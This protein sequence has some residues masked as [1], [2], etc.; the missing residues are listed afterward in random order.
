MARICLNGGTSLPF[1]IG[2]VQYQTSVSITCDITVFLCT[3]F[4]I[5]ARTGWC[6]GM[7]KITLPQGDRHQCPQ[8]YHHVW[9]TISCKCD[10]HKRHIGFC[11]HYIL[12]SFIEHFLDMFLSRY[13]L[14]SSPYD[15]ESD[16]WCWGNSCH[17][18]SSKNRMFPSMA[19]L[20][21]GAAS[22]VDYQLTR[23]YSRYYY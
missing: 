20:A 22:L 11:V 19:N 18:D 6:A 7:T 10:N 23:K 16:K 15:I 12:S 9:Y 21:R 17:K 3:H 1:Y 13:W 2:V 5:S 4:S 14:S 8:P